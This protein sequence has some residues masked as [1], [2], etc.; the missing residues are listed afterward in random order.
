MANV[1]QL[2]RFGAQDGVNLSARASVVFIA[3]ILMSRNL[4]D[5]GNQDAG[6]A[7]FAPISLEHFADSPV[8]AGR[9][10]RQI[11]L[12]P[13]GRYKYEIKGPNN[14]TV[15]LKADP[16]ALQCE[17]PPRSAS[18]AFGTLHIAP[19]LPGFLARYPEVR[20]DMAIGD[21][22]VDL[23]EEG[24]DTYTATDGL[25]AWDMV[26][27][28]D[29][30]PEPTPVGLVSNFDATKGIFIGNSITFSPANPAVGWD[31]SSGMSASSAA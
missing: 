15:P 26:K 11:D 10:Y 28:G 12:D 5:P 1:A 23:A 17:V 18:V 24:F 22:F 8:F 2:V 21:R 4:L 25:Q 7:T 3:S 20:I 16:V 6:L 14:A 19:A 13:G 30:G 27:G 31:H 29:F 9:H